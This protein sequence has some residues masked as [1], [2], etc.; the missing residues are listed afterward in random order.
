MATRRKDERREPGFPKTLPQ[1]CLNG[2]G[3]ALDR[4]CAS[5]SVITW[6]I[7][8]FLRNGSHLWSHGDGRSS[9]NV[10]QLRSYRSLIY[11]IQI[12]SVGQNVYYVL[13]ADRRIPHRRDLHSADLC[14]VSS[15]NMKPRLQ[16]GQGHHPYHISL[17]MT[18]L[19][20]NYWP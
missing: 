20:M 5:F 6:D 15:D 7:R 18:F 17:A 1:S 14:I 19:H 8:Q 12:P 16:R 4:G 10:T 2:C 11:K 3:S 9:P 13:R